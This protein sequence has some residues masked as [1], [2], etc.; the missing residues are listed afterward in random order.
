MILQ[1]L[2]RLIFR[3]SFSIGWK[4]AKRNRINLEWWD[5]K[6]NIGDSLALVIYQWMLDRNDIKKDAKVTKII[7]V[8]TI[9]SLIGMVP[10]DAVIW[11]TGIHRI[12]SIYKLVKYKRMVK[13]DIRAVRG[14]LTKNV[15]EYAGYNCS[16]CN[17]GDPAILMPLIY[18]PS[19]KKKYDYSVIHHID[20]INIESNNNYHMIDVRTTNYKYFV[21][22]ICSSKLIISSSLHGI[23]LAESYGVPAIFINEDMNDEL[24]KFYDWYFSTG[25]KNVVMATSISEALNITPMELPD[26]AEMRNNL[27]KCFPYDLF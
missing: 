5:K 9:G 22:E 25:R 19:V 4:K 11:G 23:I 1:R 17:Y 14:P 6:E 3:N 7:H 2:Y 16:N 15:L 20:K 21:E 12:S 13:Y 18:T 27:L 10:F 26:L 24:F 8:M